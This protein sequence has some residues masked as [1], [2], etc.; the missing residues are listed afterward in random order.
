[1]DEMKIVEDWMNGLINWVDLPVEVQEAIDEAMVAYVDESGEDDAASETVEEPFDD[2][3]VKAAPEQ[4]SSANVE[5]LHKADSEHRFTLGPW[6]IPNRYDA[7]G[8]WTDADELQKSLWEY[9]KSGDRGIRLQHNKDI[10]AGEW[11]EAMSFPVP[12]TIG[13]TKDANSKQ[14]EYPAGT[15]FLGVQWKPWAWELVK[16][17]KIQGFSIGGAAARIDMSM[18]DAIAKASFSGDRSAAGRYAANM[19]WQNSPAQQRVSDRVASAM[20][21]AGLNL[22]ARLNA[23]RSRKFDRE[24]RGE[25]TPS[26]IDRLKTYFSDEYTNPKP[27][28]QVEAERRE[29]DAKRISRQRGGDIQAVSTPKGDVILQGGRLIQ[30]KTMG[31]SVDALKAEMRVAARLAD[32][33]KG[34]SFGGDRSAAGRYAAEMRWRN[35]RIRNEISN[36]LGDA[37]PPVTTG[38]KRAAMLAPSLASHCDFDG[39]AKELKA[40]GVGI[41]DF[42][43]KDGTKVS[44][45]VYKYL[46]PE[47]QQLWQDTT[48][49]FVAPQI[50]K[51]APGELT[52]YVKGG[53]AAS[54]K[55]TP[56]PDIKT[57]AA[58]PSRGEYEAVLVNPDEIKV[59]LPEYQQL[60]GTEESRTSAAQDDAIDGGGKNDVWKEGANFV[61]EES[62]MI[63]QMVTGT[64]IASGRNVVIDG[65]AN[66]G[67]AKQLRKVDS[68]REAGADKV[69]GVFYSASIENAL[70]RAK[71][72]S[73][74]TGREVKDDTLISNHK[75]VSRNFPEYVKSGKFDSIGVYDTNSQ[76]ANGRPRAI[77]MFESV[78][79]KSSI[80]EP[81]LYQAFLD[82]VNYGEQK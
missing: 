25:K 10:V 55:S 30:A 71:S 68:Y 29:A 15:V 54:G 81:A 50:P 82:K 34:K 2:E 60:I 1:M 19:R 66:N 43:T 49:I 58:D 67:L 78:A 26:L 70:Q 28:Y 79:G 18:P 8:E 13:M 31:K 48:A 5:L 77:K 20:G 21:Y 63:A 23:A 64:A 61:H 59:R 40:N 14:V 65:V 39:L 7:H 72:R 4:L 9:V 36:L 74:K 3:L 46:T 53:G 69:V 62:A 22:A 47:R 57:P 44:E 45:I 17:G 75:G 35:E 76:D 51:A 38:G 73:L 6:Y 11:V 41:D 42:E 16:A 33:K 37:R 56:S 32:F 24:Q 12:V 27:L 80:I 52:V